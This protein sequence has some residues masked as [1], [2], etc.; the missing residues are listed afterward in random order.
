MGHSHLL[1]VQVN[2]A[3][4]SANNRY[5]FVGSG[6]RFPLDGHIDDVLSI[7]KVAADKKL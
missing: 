2:I 7:S 5:L 3:H 6:G 4:L 1:D